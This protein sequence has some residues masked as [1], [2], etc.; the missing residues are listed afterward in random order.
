MKVWQIL[1]AAPDVNLAM[2]LA[3]VISVD[4]Q[5]STITR[6]DGTP[7]EFRVVDQDGNTLRK[8]NNETDARNFKNGA[9]ARIDR[10]ARANLNPNSTTR[11]PALAPDADGQLKQV[12]ESVDDKGNIKGYFEKPDGTKV[13]FNGPPREVGAKLHDLLPEGKRVRFTTKLGNISRKIVSKT[14]RI[15]STS[16]WGILGVGMTVITGLNIWDEYRQDVA[17]LRIMM[18]EEFVDSARS[19]EIMRRSYR[20][21]NI[22]AW[23]AIGIEVVG[24]IGSLITGAKI[25]RLARMGRATF[26]LIPGPGWLVALLWTAVMEGGIWVFS[27]LLR[28]YGPQWFAETFM[29]GW[30][31]GEN[32]SSLPPIDENDPELAAAVQR[33]VDNPE[34]PA[35]NETLGRLQNRIR[36]IPQPSSSGS[37]GSSNGSSDA[38]TTGSSGSSSSSSASGFSQSAIDRVRAA[39]G[40]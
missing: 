30:G 38:S 27:W 6:P 5:P 34:S 29:E 37:S 40:N 25:L 3:D 28:K 10:A 19:R 22:T 33:D 2:D 13:K 39:A 17:A 11:T 21:I 23:T 9:Q 4:V 1:E 20:L 18:E 15:L 36:S 26:L 32:D 7:A 35:D 31:V 8:F 14:S 12:I 24:G 16:M